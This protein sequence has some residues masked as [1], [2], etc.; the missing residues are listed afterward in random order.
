MGR[1]IRVYI[2]PNKIEFYRINERKVPYKGKIKKFPFNF[3]ALKYILEAA[4]K[5]EKEIYTDSDEIVIE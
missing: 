5:L 2:Y 1:L 4:G 3:R